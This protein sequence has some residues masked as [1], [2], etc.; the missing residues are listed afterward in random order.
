MII[1]GDNTVD[2]TYLMRCLHGQ[3]EM[4]RFWRLSYLLDLVFSGEMKVILYL[5]PNMLV[6]FLEM[7][8]FRVVI[9]STS[10]VDFICIHPLKDPKGSI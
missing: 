6:I 10:I 7:A 8:E 5:G 1:T 3:R 2:I 4:K 9:G